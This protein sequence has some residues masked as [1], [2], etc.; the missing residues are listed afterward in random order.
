MKETELAQKFVEYLSDMYDLYFEVGLTDIVGKK[1]NIVINVEVKKTLN[2]KVIQQAYNNI[3][4]SHYSYIAVPRKS[5]INNP[6]ALIIC[7]KFGIGVLL[8]D[9][10]FAYTKVYEKVKP[11]LNRHAYTK[12]AKKLTED[13]MYKRTTPGAKSGDTITAF[14]V[15]VENLESYVSRHN[16]CAIK[17]A[18]DNISHHYGSISSAKSSII[19]YIDRGIIKNIKREGNKLYINKNY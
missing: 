12:Y 17:E 11:K 8:Y 4:S 14:S 15:T 5:A 10:N 19:S 1:D 3:R 18:L 7:E 16:G 9:E 6:F 13:S 2:F